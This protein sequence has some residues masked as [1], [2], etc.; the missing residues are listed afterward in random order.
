M[1]SAAGVSEYEQSLEASWYAG[2]HSRMSQADLVRVG[3]AVMTVGS[4]AIHFAVTESHFHE[5]W[6]FGLFFALVGWLQIV[7][8]VGVLAVPSRGL[9]LAGMIGSLVLIVLW[10][11]SRTSGIPIGPEPWTP[12]H[13]GLADV[14]STTFEASAVVGGGALLWSESLDWPPSASAKLGSVVL[15]VGVASAT[16][17]A[18]VMA[19]PH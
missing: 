16:T 7:W 3:C 17:W 2:P 10:I 19:G 13:V 9:Y 15:A 5:Y 6:V 8:A 4:A 11:N 1:Q 18:I 14:L 12:E